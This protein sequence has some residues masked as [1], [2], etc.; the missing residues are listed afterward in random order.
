MM[1]RPLTDINPIT[2]VYG[3]T[4]GPIQVPPALT[5]PPKHPQE[6]PLSCE[7]LDMMV[8]SVSHIHLI[9]VTIYTPGRNELS[10]A[11]AF[12]SKGAVEGVQNLNT[13]VNLICHLLLAFHA[14]SP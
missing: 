14:T 3:N 7:D 10:L 12:L 11:T 9:T 5:T 2:S 13:L 1:I 4:I 8:T 6:L